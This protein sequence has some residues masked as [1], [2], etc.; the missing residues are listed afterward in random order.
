MYDQGQGSSYRTLTQHN[1]AVQLLSGLPEGHVMFLTGARMRST[2][3]N[4]PFSA[5]ASAGLFGST[6][7]ACSTACTLAWTTELL[8]MPTSV[9]DM[10][11][12]LHRAHKH[13]TTQKQIV[14]GLPSS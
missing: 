3:A 13:S 8:A 14:V 1:T 10:L 11:G 7:S 5:A 2:S 9:V 6:P 12:F 4:A